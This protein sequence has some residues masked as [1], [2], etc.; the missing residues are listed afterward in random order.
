MGVQHGIMTKLVKD[1][2]NRNR[3]DIVWW[4]NPTRDKIYKKLF[5]ANQPQIGA[6]LLWQYLFWWC[7]HHQ[8]SHVLTW[9][10]LCFPTI[11][12]NIISIGLCPLAMTRVFTRLK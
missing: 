7:N 6:A 11:N 12:L 5:L 10:R 2:E 9:N 4:Q 8:T 3:M 1:K